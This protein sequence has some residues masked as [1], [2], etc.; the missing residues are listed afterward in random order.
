MSVVPFTASPADADATA[1]TVTEA[2]DARQRMLAFK[3]KLD[4]AMS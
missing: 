4:E 2:A 1:T 3:R